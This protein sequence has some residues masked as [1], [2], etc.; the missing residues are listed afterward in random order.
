MAGQVGQGPHRSAMQSLRIVELFRDM[1]ADI[2]AN[3][4]CAFLFIA[5]RA[6]CTIRDVETGLNTSN[7]SATRLTQRLA[8][9]KLNNKPGFGLVDYEIDPTDARVRRLRLTSKGNRLVETIHG[10]MGG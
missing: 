4:V 5:A 10:I 7:A 9:I 3:V 8:D 1:D 6:D 2:T